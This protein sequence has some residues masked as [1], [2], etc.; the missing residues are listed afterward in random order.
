MSDLSNEPAA[1]NAPNGE[2][3]LPNG[4]PASQLRGVALAGGGYLALREG[5]GML[6]RLGGVVVVTRLIGPHNYG[7][8]VAAAAFVTLVASAAQLGAE[9]WLIRQPHEPTEEQ[10]NQTFTALVVV[11][12]VVTLV[13]LAATWPVS[14]FYTN[15]EAIRAFRILALAVPV[16]I[17][18]A[19]AQ[20]KLERHFRYRKLAWLELAGDVALYA[21]AVPLAFAGAGVYAPV[22]GYISWQTTL[23][24]GSAVLAGLRPRWRWSRTL[25]RTLLRHGFSYSSSTWVDQMVALANP[26]IVGG[27]IGATGVGLVGL[28]IRL[29]D[30]AGFALRAAWRLGLAAISR[31]AHDPA[32]LRSAIEEGMFAQALVLGVPLAGLAVLSPWLIPLVFGSTWKDAVPVYSVLALARLV[33][34]AGLV[35]MTVLFAKARNG[36]VIGAVLTRGALLVAA[37][38]VL[39]PVA[40]IDGF[41]YASLIAAAAWWLL[42][43]KVRQVVAFSYRRVFPVVV[44]LGIPM[45]FPLAPWPSRLALLAPATALIILPSIRS[46]ILE[47]THV[48]LRAVLPRRSAANA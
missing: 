21:V 30:T 37:S 22:I 11:S 25:T 46:A 20:A 23:F 40:G 12:I 36:A 3:R 27:F 15:G 45:L 1:A 32:R 39:I 34:S 41:A 44:A 35:L 8:Y 48:A 42:D 31:V 47:Y 18:W 7:I 29:V 5:L 33:G 17:L 38:A 14:L 16:N 2:N 24:V 4:Q 43:R 19:P 10:Y 9:V 6:I 28:A 13:A 26:V